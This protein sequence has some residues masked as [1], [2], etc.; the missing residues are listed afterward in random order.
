VITRRQILGGG[1]ALAMAGCRTPRTDEVRIGYIANLM[2]AQALLALRA[3]DF[4]RAFAPAKVRAR[5]FS[6]GPSVVE[7]LFA[8]EVDLAYLGPAPVLGAH[9]L[10]K[11]KAMRVIAG[12][13]ANGVAVVVGKNSDI[14]RFEDL[15]GKRVATPQLGNTQDVSARHFLRKVL[16]QKNLDNV[17]PFPI[18][19]HGAL[20][21]RGRI[22]AAWVTEPWA[23]R[24]AMESGGRVLVEERDLWPNR[25]FCQ[26]LVV[27]SAE[28][29]RERPGAVERFLAVHHDWTRSLSSDPKPHLPAIEDALFR[30]T[31]KHLAPAVLERAI[32]HAEFIDDPLEE[33]LRTMAVWSHEAGFSRRVADLDGL[34]DTSFLRVVSA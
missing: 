30:A 17:F 33:T 3:G 2:Q 11:G 29:L 26:S 19:E 22:D 16:G 32:G 10:S 5:V 4:A 21:A 28:M 1:L 12:A 8:G 6:A 27:A 7:A 25:R 23:T 24:L 9:V 15:A 14:T 31:G 18:A 20:L 13:A 34:V